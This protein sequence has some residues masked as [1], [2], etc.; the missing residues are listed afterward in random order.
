MKDKT[1]INLLRWIAVLP[2]VCVA[3]TIA[4][5]FIIFLMKQLFTI[6]GDYELS[7]IITIFYI[8]WG[9]STIW[10]FIVSLI[11]CVAKMMA[12]VALV[13]YIAP[14]KKKLTANIF[15]WIWVLG[16][17]STYGSLSLAKH[18]GL[19]AE[20]EVL[21]WGIGSL[22]LLIITKVHIAEKS[23]YFEKQD[24]AIDEQ[25]AINDEPNSNE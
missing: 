19:I 23:K 16:V 6:V 9:S 25:I 17:L 24:K 13:M 11:L 2:A 22:M 18:R 10:P 14:T 5:E 3:N 21:L 15:F 20:N 12:V 1:L 7:P 4:N 8:P